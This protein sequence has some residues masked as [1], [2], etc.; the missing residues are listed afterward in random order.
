MH[1]PRVGRFFAVDPLAGKY[2]W[3]STYAFSENRVI[4]GVELEGLEYV[5]ANDAKIYAWKGIIHVNSDNVSAAT[6][7]SMTVLVYG[8]NSIGGRD[9]GNFQGTYES[10]FISAFDVDYRKYVP[11]NTFIEWLHDK[12]ATKKALAPKAGVDHRPLRND[13]GRNKSYSTRENIGGTTRG[14]KGAGIFII[15]VEALNLTVFGFEKYD[16]AL[17]NEHH[18]LMID[19]VF[20]ALVKALNSKDANGNDYIPDKFKYDD[21]AIGAISNVILFGDTGIS[22]SGS[23]Y[24]TQSEAKEIVSIGLKIYN[25]LAEKT[26]PKRMKEPSSK[27]PG[28][29]ILELWKE[30]FFRDLGESLEDILT[31]EENEEEN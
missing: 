23:N 29:S 24:L 16:E 22:T 15:A 4:D 18:I 10:T 21:V 2:P 6:R 7:E 12:N 19:K 11:K 1:D 20:P 8:M 9:Y 3:N 25:E 27:G 26:A 30:Q 17:I 5:S 31:N 14:S 13:G 28:I